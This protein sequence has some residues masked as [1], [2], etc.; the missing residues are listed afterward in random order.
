MALGLTNVNQTKIKPVEKYN[1]GDGSLNTVDLGYESSIRCNGSLV[2]LN[3]ATYGR[4]SNCRYYSQTEYPY[5]NGDGINLWAIH[6]RSRQ[7]YAGSDE[8]FQ[9]LKDEQ[10]K[11][12]GE[13]YIALLGD[14]PGVSGTNAY[15][16]LT[17]IEGEYTISTYI[18]YG[19]LT[20]GIYISSLKYTVDGTQMTLKEMVDNGACKPL[21]LMHSGAVN[22]NYYFANALNLYTGGQTSSGNYPQFCNIFMLNSGHTL[23]GISYYANK[24]RGSSS[25]LDG[26]RCIFAYDTDIYRLHLAE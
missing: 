26:I 20:T 6:R 16:F 12:I 23:S 19:A 4:S 17:P 24:A 8:D 2:M 5:T 3:A 11:P 7:L 9:A 1:Y 18:E 14:K 10:Y 22:G 21:V 25:Y 13:K 15:T